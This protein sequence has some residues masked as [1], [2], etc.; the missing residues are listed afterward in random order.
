MELNT[1]IEIGAWLVSVGSIGGGMRMQQ[2]NFQR[3]LDDIT[4]QLDSHEKEDQEVHGDVREMKT[5]LR[6]IREAME[7][8]DRKLT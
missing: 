6:W 8:I 7:R 3:Q 4:E 5:D 2:R 1:M